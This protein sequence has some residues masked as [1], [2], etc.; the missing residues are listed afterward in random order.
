MVLRNAVDLG[1]LLR[2]FLQNSNEAGEGPLLRWMQLGGTAHTFEVM[3]HVRHLLRSMFWCVG[4]LYFSRP[5][6]NKISCSVLCEEGK[7]H[8][9]KSAPSGIVKELEK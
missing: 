8:I 4:Y 9:R 3:H 7:T 6:D 5:G 2:Q 1:G